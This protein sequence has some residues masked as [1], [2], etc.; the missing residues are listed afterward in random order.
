[1]LPIPLEDEAV[2]QQS[3]SHRKKPDGWMGKPKHQIRTMYCTITKRTFNKDHIAF[4]LKRDGG[5]PTIYLW[6]PCENEEEFDLICEDLD[7]GYDWK[8]S[9]DPDLEQMLELRQA[10]YAW[11]RYVTVTAFALFCNSQ[12]ALR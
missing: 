12:S 3:E 9:Y 2:Q 4:E 7:Q 8:I 10:S 5:G 6:F 11:T 1:M